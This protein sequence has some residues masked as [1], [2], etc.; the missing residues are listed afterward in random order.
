MM[1]N[2]TGSRLIANATASALFAKYAV[3]SNPPRPSSPARSP[4]QLATMLRESSRV[5]LAMMD[6][7]TEL[8]E[9]ARRGEDCS[10]EDGA[11]V[12]AMVKKS[13]AVLQGVPLTSRRQICKP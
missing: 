10:E 3:E 13:C 4:H 11:H 2:A 5:L 8:F 6:A 9:L 12:A 7:V 1:T